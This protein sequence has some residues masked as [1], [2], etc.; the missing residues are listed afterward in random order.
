M[1]CVELLDLG[2]MMTKHRE[3][4]RD[5]PSGARLQQRLNEIDQMLE[6]VMSVMTNCP[7]A[8]RLKNGLDSRVQSPA[9]GWDAEV[10][11]KLQDF[12]F[13]PSASRE[14]AKDAFLVQQGNVYVNQQLARFV[15]LQYRND[16]LTLKHEAE[17]ET[18]PAASRS[19]GFLGETA[20]G[21]GF[22]GKDGKDHVASEKENLFYDLLTVL[23]R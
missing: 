11:A 3:D 5:P 6:D 18:S 21:D 13:N 16:L 22:G 12:F 19:H 15:L 23:H 9:G 17:L 10:S 7:P 8:L 2:R 20:L 1:S 14:V 4:K